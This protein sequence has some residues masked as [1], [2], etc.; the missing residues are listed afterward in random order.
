MPVQTHPPQKWASVELLTQEIDFANAK[1]IV[2][3]INHYHE[4][5]TKYDAEYY[6]TFGVPPE[7]PETLLAVM[8]ILNEHLQRVASMEFHAL[9]RLPNEEQAIPRIGDAILFRHSFLNALAVIKDVIK[10]KQATSDPHAQCYLEHFIQRWMYKFCHH[11]FSWQA[12][13]PQLV[14][15]FAPELEKG[16]ESFESWV[17]LFIHLTHLHSAPNPEQMGYNPSNMRRFYLVFSNLLWIYLKEGIVIPFHLQRIFVEFHKN[18][19]FHYADFAGDS[20]AIQ[21]EHRC[22]LI[23]PEAIEPFFREL[24]AVTFIKRAVLLGLMV[25]PERKFAVSHFCDLSI[26]G[27][28]ELYQFIGHKLESK[29]LSQADGKNWLHHAYQTISAVVAEKKIVANPAIPQEI[30]AIF[31]TPKA[32]VVPPVAGEESSPLE[33][34][35][36][37][38]RTLNIPNLAPANNLEELEDRGTSKKIMIVQDANVL[39][40]IVKN[41][42][43]RGSLTFPELI[44]FVRIPFQVL[45]QPRPGVREGRKFV[46]FAY[47]IALGLQ[48]KHMAEFVEKLAKTEQISEARAAQLQRLYPSAVEQI[49]ALQ[50][51]NK[52]TRPLFSSQGL[53]LPDIF[54][55][56]CEALRAV[57]MQQYSYI[58]SLLEYWI[59]VEEV[60]YGIAKATAVLGNVTLPT[61]SKIETFITAHS[62]EY[63]AVYEKA[64]M[65]AGL[66]K[67]Y[68]KKKYN[69][70]LQAQFVNVKIKNDLVTL[71]KTTPMNLA[72]RIH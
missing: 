43:I 20:P 57:F 51:L 52:D 47:L 34:A 42:E 60:F 9:V 25:E 58:Q 53:L 13:Q 45:Q 33:E 21:A 23:A 36:A 68:F 12:L 22:L 55:E 59:L 4:K 24:K 46:S 40:L 70:E 5:N 37:A 15:L 71:A 44:E 28:A 27:V 69:P 26:K 66:L 8:K 61:A 49:G 32:A 2:A 29:K 7:N 18:D 56:K 31:G 67:V 16:K 62:E 39:D 65:F 10:H 54:I 64:L 3:E 1:K 35:S 50:K 38:P 63:M 11:V 17:L 6:E 41:W 14:A 19:F 48:E 72:E 30:R